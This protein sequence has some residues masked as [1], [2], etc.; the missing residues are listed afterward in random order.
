MKATIISIGDELLIG[1]TVNTN[2]S[3]MAQKLTE[4]GIN[5]GLI[6]TIG[7]NLEQMKNLIQTGLQKYDLVLTTG[8]LGPTHDDVTKQAICELLDRELVEHTPTLEYVQSFFKRRGIPF[9]QSNYGQAMIPEGAEVL[10]NNMGTAPGLWLPLN[11]HILVVMPGV[12]REMKFLMEQR[13]RPR[14]L[15]DMQAVDQIRK[16][17]YRRTAGV[18][19]SELSDRYLPEISDIAQEH[20]SVAFL[21]G[22]EG[23]TLRIT[24]QGNSNEAAD[25]H[26][27]AILT[28]IEQQVGEFIYADQKSDSLSVAVGKRL[29]DT[30]QSLATAE[31]C[32][33]GLLGSTITDVPGSSEYFLGGEITYSNEAKMRELQVEEED[34]KKYGAVSGPV[35]GQMAKAVAQRNNASIGIST[36]GIAGPGG[37]SDEK[38][39]GTV[40]FGFYAS[41]HADHS[42]HFVCKAVL[43]KDRQVNKERS[44]AIAL[45]LIRRYLDGIDP[46]PYGMKKQEIGS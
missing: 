4:W 15:D 16:V 46:L 35:A 45:E 21:P 24:A 20:G 3:W 2:A 41:E 1:D 40:W 25:S 43:T 39:V 6:S 18:G 12:P 44:V 5:V 26:L 19:E 10:Q 7:D 11:G 31:S 34:L 33:G 42:K 36:T 30:G 8:G 28:Y 29:K 9:T 13:I 17:V 22:I 32:T 38:P 37:G 14:I 23:V 27:E